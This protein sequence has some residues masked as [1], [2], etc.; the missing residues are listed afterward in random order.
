MTEQSNNTEV[1]KHVC[2]TDFDISKHENRLLSELH[3]MISK[4][5]LLVVWSILLGPLIKRDFSGFLVS[6]GKMAF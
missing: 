5:I 4:D 3:W 6:V 2:F 1:Y